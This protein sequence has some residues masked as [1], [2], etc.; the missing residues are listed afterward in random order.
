[1]WQ[2]KHSKQPKSIAIQ[3]VTWREQ[4]QEAWWKMELANSI[5]VSL[6]EQNLKTGEWEVLNVY[7]LEKY[8]I[9]TFLVEIK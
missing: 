6:C 9:K 7:S 2:T 1:M 3:D 5:C 4:L 8:R